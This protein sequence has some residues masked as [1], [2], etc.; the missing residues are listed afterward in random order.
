MA[1]PL[2]SP[3]TIR[4]KARGATT[5]TIT[6]TIANNTAMGSSTPNRRNMKQR[7]FSSSSDDFYSVSSSCSVH[8]QTGSS[9][10]ELP[11][12]SD[13]D[14]SSSSRSYHDE[15]KRRS[16]NS[17]MMSGAYCC[18]GGRNWNC[19]FAGIRSPFLMT[20]VMFA[21]FLVF[22]VLAFRGDHAGLDMERLVGENG[23]MI[24][25]GTAAS[26]PVFTIES[27]KV[28]NIHSLRVLVKPR[29]LIMHDPRAYLRNIE[30]IKTC[31]N[32]VHS[33]DEVFA[34]MDQFR[35][36][37]FAAEFYK[38][39]VL[40]N[41]GG[42]YFDAVETVLVQHTLEDILISFGG[43]FSAYG[44]V[45]QDGNS[46]NSAMIA[47]EQPKNEILRRM[48]QFLMSASVKK[49]ER[50]PNAISQKLYQF[51]REE[52]SHSQIKW[53]LLE[54]KC[55]T[56]SDECREL[57]GMC[58]R[59]FDGEDDKESV[60]M[61]SNKGVRTRT[62]NLQYIPLP[63]FYEKDKANQTH[64]NTATVR[65]AGMVNSGEL[66]SSLPDTLRA[67]IPFIS[68]IRETINPPPPSDF[69]ET[70]NMFDIL[71]QN[72]CLPT[73]K[74]CANCLR[75]KKGANC[76]SCGSHCQ[77]F[78]ESLC[79]IDI[80]DKYVSKTISISPPAFSVDPLRYIPRIIHQTWFEEVDRNKY[81]NMSR[82]IE[83]WKQSGWD[84][85]FYDDKSSVE[86]LQTHFPPEVIEAYDALI[87]GAFKADLFR[88]CVLLIYGGVYVDVDV[89]L[90]SN[91][92]LVIDPDIG[93]M[94]A[95]DEVRF[96]LKL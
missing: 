92:D 30:H 19:I 78:C 31:T 32:G 50:N 13:M 9:S 53:K 35:S 77:C 87:P 42:V 82:L 11:I 57:H 89:I 18:L 46:M 74:E 43:R 47:I 76:Q 66:I 29:P 51:V 25:D 61:L 62:P 17:M 86:F 4:T 96:L 48:I 80:P 67:D 36:F 84:Y 2:S 63:Y 73:S 65:G 10:S 88:Y 14:G 20:I 56:N 83:S 93:F 54:Q 7:I 16:K 22:G 58:C 68:T 8:Q 33:V 69:G 81:K 3:L 49:L 55:Q 85:R 94:T 44:I 60:L 23:P 45:D 1:P 27:D 24:G 95:V 6:T 41:S 40:Y 38:F 26:L 15:K 71:L 91:L 52:L 28:S 70:P 34:K 90:E 64:R 75:N 79:Q 39:C 59:I 37:D 21:L 5:A 12:A 72:D